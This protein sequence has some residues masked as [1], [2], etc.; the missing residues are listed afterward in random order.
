MADV[1]YGIN[2]GNTSLQPDAVSYNTSTNST[3]IELR[4]DTGKG[5]TRKDVKSAL[6]QLLNR[7]N[8][9]RFSTYPDL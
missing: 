6:E 9:G 8:D 4:I 1:F 3:D 2:R 5:T 7:I